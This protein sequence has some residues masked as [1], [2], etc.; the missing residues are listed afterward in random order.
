MRKLFLYT[1]LVIFTLNIVVAANKSIAPVKQR[2]YRINKVEPA[3][4]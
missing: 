2:K 1:S 4:I 3:T